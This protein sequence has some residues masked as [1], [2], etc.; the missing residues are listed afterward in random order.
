[1]IFVYILIGLLKLFVI[2]QM[3]N[4]II[5]ILNEKQK[6]REEFEIQRHD[7]NYCFFFRNGKCHTQFEQDCRD[8]NFFIWYPKEN[9]E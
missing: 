2:Y 9:E 8:N 4:I 6:E 5:D 7:C 3:S 1:M